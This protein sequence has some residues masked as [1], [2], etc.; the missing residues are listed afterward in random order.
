MKLLYVTYAGNPVDGASAGLET[1]QVR[2]LLKELAR[3]VSIEWLALVHESTPDPRALSAYRES[4]DAKGVGFDLVV[5]PSSRVRRY[6]AAW[7]I[8]RRKIRT[9]GPDMIHARRLV[10]T[11]LA[12]MNKTR[13]R[14]VVYDARGIASAEAFGEAGGW[15]R[16]VG[17]AAYRYCLEVLGSRFS[18]GTVAVSE[19]MRRYYAKL[20]RRPV[21]TIPNSAAPYFRF[22]S[23]LRAD[24]RRRLG[25]GN[26]QLVLVYA[27][28][29]A[30]WWQWPEGIARSFRS[31][32]A[33]VSGARL[34]VLT[35]HPIEPLQLLLTEEER[36]LTA[37]FRVPH[38]QVPGYLCAS[39]VGLLVLNPKS[40]ANCQASAVKF[41]EYL[42]CGLPVFTLKV[43]SQAAEGVSQSG[44]GAV[45]E[46]PDDIARHAEKLLSG[47]AREAA[48][49]YG[50]TLS[51]ARAADSYRALYSSLVKP[52]GAEV[53]R[54]RRAAGL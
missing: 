5:L 51:V 46:A 49:T 44:A 52:W 11:A 12:L 13:G 25:Y 42:A 6:V 29:L 14:Q 8:V 2:E 54:K 30:S 32:R 39:D 47:P 43:I 35:P 38:E 7:W 37:C 19:P 27:G 21:V 41:A 24:M 33:A 20:T 28:G 53:G 34:L 18:A 36:R 22:D 31:F 17:K 26:G 48:L 45:G 23:T 40:R 50:A 9:F 15:L 4:L 3:D 1:G 10:A 16:R